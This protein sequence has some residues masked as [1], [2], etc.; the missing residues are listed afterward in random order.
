MQVMSWATFYRRA[1]G[2]QR[3]L[4]GNILEHSPFITEVA[5]FVKPG[6]KV[7]EIGAGTG[8]MGW[9]LAQAG[10][11]VISVDNDPEILKM[12]VISAV[13][14][15]ADIE[16][17]EADAFHLPFAER[18]F[19]VAFSEGL[20]EHYEN[21]DIGLLVAEH[22]RVAD[23]VAVSVPLQGSRNPALGNER[24]MTLP[25]W[26]AILIPMGA[27]QGFI[28]GSEPNGCFTFERVR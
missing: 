8:V 5:K 15:G 28:Y 24:W 14:L 20:L 12:A 21:V 18:E 9:P 13:L 16:Y 11:K 6:D 23:V 4:E 3:L 2:N 17:R 22:Q 1:C 10:V 19:K 27:C 25:E 26:E 7:L